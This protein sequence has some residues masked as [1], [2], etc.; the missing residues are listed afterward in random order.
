MVYGAAEGG[1]DDETA[2]IR[3]LG[4]AGFATSLDTVA[5]QARWAAVTGLLLLR[6]HRASYDRLVASLATTRAASIGTVVL[7]IEAR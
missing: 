2:L 6:E 7:A 4:D 5:G 3:F 1:A